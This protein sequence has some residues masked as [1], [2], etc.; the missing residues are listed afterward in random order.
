MMFQKKSLEGLRIHEVY[1]PQ[2]SDPM[3]TFTIP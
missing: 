3:D 2:P 1:S